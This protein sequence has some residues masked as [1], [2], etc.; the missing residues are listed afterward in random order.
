MFDREA[1]TTKRRRW[2]WVLGI[3]TLAIG[4]FVW[5]IYQWVQQ[6]TPEKVLNTPVVRSYIERLVGEEHA[7][8][9]DMLPELLGFTEPRTY[10]VLFQNNTELR[11]GGG[12]IGSY[13][14]VRATNGK[15]EILDVQGTETLDKQAPASWRVQPPEVITRELGVDRWYFRDS[16]WS[17]DFVTNAKRAREFYVAEGGVARDSIQTVV[18]VDT[19]VIERLLALTG[20]ITVDGIEF[21]SSTVVEKLEYDVE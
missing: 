7:E 14:V 21:T 12:F 5:V 11:P 15:F 1:Q 17:P 16:N 18:V 6:L 13:G 9:V 10:L 3:L 4:I 8:F 19:T 20:P 2:P